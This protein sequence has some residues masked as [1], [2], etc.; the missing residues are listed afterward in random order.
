MSA[1]L[2]FLIKNLPTLLTIITTLIGLFTGGSSVLSHAKLTHPAHVAAAEADP[3]L[4]AQTNQL[5]N[6]HVYGQAALSL[7]LFGLAGA[8]GSGQSLVSRWKTAHDLVEA[9]GGPQN[10][11]QFKAAFDQLNA[12]AAASF[13]RFQDAQA[14]QKKRAEVVEAVHGLPAIDLARV[15]DHVGTKVSDTVRK[16]LPGA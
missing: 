13:K 5:Y 11:Q 15:V 9:L 1:L 14:E 10:I 4:A 3:E 6:S 12:E 2:A 7:A 8:F 16:L